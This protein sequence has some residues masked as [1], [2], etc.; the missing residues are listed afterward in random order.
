LANARRDDSSVVA[1]HVAGDPAD[2]DELVA[3]KLSH[4]QST[5]LESPGGAFQKMEAMLKFLIANH[6]PAVIEESFGALAGCFWNQRSR[7]PEPA[8]S[9]G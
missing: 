6:K 9:T 8:A 5:L 1:A 7:M 3:V 2:R 4:C